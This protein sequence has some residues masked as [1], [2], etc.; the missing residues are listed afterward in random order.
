[1]GPISLKS[2]LRGDRVIA[3][4]NL[5]TGQFSNIEHLNGRPDF[6]FVLGSIPNADLI[7]DLV[8]RSDAIF[9]LAAN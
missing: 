4:D 6:E 7:D 5:T 2:C 9:H 8:S 1:L 3:L